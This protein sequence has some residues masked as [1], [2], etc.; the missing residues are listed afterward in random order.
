MSFI[1]QVVQCIQK[2]D[3]EGTLLERED[4]LTGYSGK[5]LYGTLQRLAKDVLNDD[6]CYVEVGVYQGLTLL[7]S[8]MANENGAFYG[9]DNFAFFDPEG[10]N[11]N[12]VEAR[13]SKLGLENTILINEDY[14]E[15]LENLEKHIGDKKVGIYFIDGPHDYRSQLMCLLLIKPYLA[16]NAVILIDDS[17]YRHVRQA[18]RDF[19]Q[20]NPAFKLLFESY[21]PA[22]PMNLK[23][24][25]KQHALDGWWDGINIIVKDSKNA[26]EP[27][28]PSTVRNRSIY[29]NEHLLHASQYPEQ[30]LLVWEIIKKLRLY[31]ILN[32]LR[33]P[34]K[35][36]SGKF[37]NANTFSESLE[38]SGKF[39]KAVK[40]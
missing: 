31:P 30:A 36:F 13:T 16:E 26:L 38:Q 3:E 40:N 12:L 37:K 20:T 28:F 18:N 23:G 11:K 29:E 14:E 1:D 4:V 8:A 22:H 17:N 5:K 33:K 19:L 24:R 15:A 35:I 25:D 10:K 27:E 39:N 34:S 21:T 2:A 6:V 9:I 32:L 7:S